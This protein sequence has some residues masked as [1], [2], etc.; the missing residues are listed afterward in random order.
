M[1][2]TRRSGWSR[3][4]AVARWGGKA[5]RSLGW[6]YKCS[7]CQNLLVYLVQCFAPDIHILL[8]SSSMFCRI[9][10]SWMDGPSKWPWRAHPVRST[11][12]VAC[13]IW[14]LAPL[15]QLSVR[16]Q[17]II[18]ISTIRYHQT[19]ME[20]VP[21]TKLLK[22]LTRTVYT[23]N[24]VYTVCIANTIYTVY[25]FNMVYTVYT[26]YSVSR[27]YTASLLTLLPPLTLLSLFK[28]LWSKK[29]IMPIHIIWLYSFI[30]FWA[31]SETE[32]MGDWVTGY[33]LEIYD[34]KASAAV[35]IMLYH[36][37]GP[38]V[39]IGSDKNKE[40]LWQDDKICLSII[41]LDCWHAGRAFNRDLGSHP[42]QHSKQA[43]CWSEE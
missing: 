18:F 11:P 35:L 29:A 27:T 9:A 25:T 37:L 36:G 43:K 13:L 8:E 33:P 20:A 23:V 32:W 12:L 16:Q 3:R 15:Q 21:R 26:A 30:A 19:D 4:V 14:Q 41:G 10:N 42:S 39:W 17:N 7:W 31:K 24:I 38:L 5:A 2:K 22:L 40:H 1:K 28:Q 34:T 6:K